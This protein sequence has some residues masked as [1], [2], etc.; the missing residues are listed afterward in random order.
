[1]AFATAFL[2]P[3]P[4]EWGAM[5]EG[6]GDDGTIVRDGGEPAAQPAADQSQEGERRVRR[7]PSSRISP[8]ERDRMLKDAR[9]ID[10][11]SAMRGYDRAAVDRYVEQVNRIVAELEISASPESA[12]R[13]ALDEVS[14]ETRELLQRAHAT[15][16]EITAK[17]R[18]KADDRLQ[19]AEREAAELREAAQSEAREVREAAQ[20]EAQKLREQ[21]TH[22]AQVLR[23]TAAHEAAE[24]REAAT[25][26]TQ[27]LR[28]TAQREADEL[29][30]GAKRDADETVEAAESRTRELTRSAEN[31]WRERRRL[32]DDMRAVGE[33]LVEIGEAEARRF[34][35]MPANGA[36]PAAEASSEGEAS[37]EAVES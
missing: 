35:H 37:A 10:F 21:A 4:K 15:A 33:Q 25:R 27:Q 20:E 24:L 22:E 19:L 1:V 34:P 18:A 14:E 16:E 32:L 11:P 12:V 3:Q 6:A 23:E 13:H 8:A 30:A 9:D 36:E 28:A 7:F 2:E 29:R 26:D 31:I 5:A 17:S